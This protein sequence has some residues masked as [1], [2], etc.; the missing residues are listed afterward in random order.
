MTGAEENEKQK[1]G[2][3][4]EGTI[5][6]DAKKKCYRGEISL[7][8]TPSGRRK[9]PKVYGPTIADVQDA[10][11][12]LREEQD[13]GVKTVAAYTV[14]HAVRDWLARGLVGRSE[15][16]I[17]KN[18]ILAEK[19]VIPGLGKPRLRD[20]TADDV[21]DWLADTKSLLSTRSLK[22]CHAILRRSIA[23]AQR[24][25]KVMRNVAELVTVPNGKGG[26]PSKAMTLEQAEAVMEA[27]R[28]TRIRAYFVLSLLTGV[29]T[30]E[31]RALT[32]DRVH[33]E[34]EGEMPPHVEVWRSVRLGGDTKTKKSRRTLALPKDVVT[35]LSEHRERQA[36]IRK[37]AKGRNK[38]TEN[39][40]VFCTRYGAE[41]T[42]QS[43]RRTMAVALRSAGLP[44]EW[45]PRELRHSFVSL[46]SAHGAPVELIAHLVGHTTTAT[47]ETVYR[48][49]L[50]PVITEGADIIGKVFAARKKGSDPAA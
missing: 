45:T 29:R 31:A 46:M 11:R 21:D 7:G 23:Q 9:R 38:W 5:Y 26:R 41:L 49:E 42:A 44:V 6:W 50:R 8:Y 10:F 48:H 28:K 39:D 25:N 24:R 12:K 32:W 2:R 1:R 35:V 15:K 20:L 34:K 37:R 47:T 3:R 36:V 17:E 22:D 30:E 19:H 33:L 16:T 27:S 18:R 43:V 14:A 4:G 13:N 40:L